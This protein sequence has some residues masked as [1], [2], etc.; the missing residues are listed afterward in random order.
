MT[1]WLDGKFW[2]PWIRQT[3]VPEIETLRDVMLNNILTAL[4][5]AE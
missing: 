5:N 1:M 2:A 3:F 4:P